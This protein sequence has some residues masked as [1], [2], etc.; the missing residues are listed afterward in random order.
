MQ[1]TKARKVQDERK[2]TAATKVQA[3]QRQRTQ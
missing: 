3:K 1:T 2:D